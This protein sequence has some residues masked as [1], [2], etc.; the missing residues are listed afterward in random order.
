MKQSS[1][2]AKGHFKMAVTGLGAV[3]GGC[4][5]HIGSGADALSSEGITVS[6]QLLCFHKNSS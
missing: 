5:L 1:N 6:P 2:A 4:V 3:M